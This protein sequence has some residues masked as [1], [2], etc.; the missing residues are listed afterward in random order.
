MKIYTKTGDDGTTGLIGGHRVKKNDIRLEAYGTVDE[1]NSWIGL[2]R[3]CRD[4]E[5]VITD[6]IYI[7]RSLF[8]IC[9]HLATDRENA[10]GEV[11][12]IAAI[13]GEHIS[14]LESG[15]DRMNSEL[16]VLNNFII[17]GGSQFTSYCHVA[18]TVCRRAERR[19]ISLSEFTKID[20]NLIIFVNRLSDYLFTLARYCSFKHGVNEIIWKNDL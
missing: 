14:F 7:Q 16:P 8:S 3:S 4:M 18:R 11:P 10:I 12:V 2:I 9:G 13:T 6:L 17:P 15:I 5:D 1:L 19:I 20:N